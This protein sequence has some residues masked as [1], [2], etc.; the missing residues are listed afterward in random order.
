MKFEFKKRLKSFSVLQSALKLF[1]LKGRRQVSLRRFIK[2][3]I[4]LHY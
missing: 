1:I 2:I 4:I 3:G